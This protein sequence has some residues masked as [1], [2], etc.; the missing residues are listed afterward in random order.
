MGGAGLCARLA[1][2]R[3]GTPAPPEGAI[4]SGLARGTPSNQ[5][6]ATLAMPRRRRM[7]PNGRTTHPRTLEKAP[8]GIEGFDQITGGGLPPGRITMIGG[9]PGSGKTV[10]AL[11]TL[12]NGAHHENEPGIFVA[13]EENAGQIVA[14]AATFDWDLPALK[15]QSLFFFDARATPETVVVG[16]FDL[17]ALL[18]ILKAKADRTGARRI[19]FDA[20]DV[21]LALLNDPAAERRELYPLPD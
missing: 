7:Q 19:V 8:T 15:D 14:N 9:G 4:S 1:S 16:E 18:A 13:F 10:F 12:V 3:A 21:L 20:I 11:Q 17:T 6:S 5:G 2:G